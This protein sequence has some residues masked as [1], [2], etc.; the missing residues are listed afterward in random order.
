MNYNDVWVY[1]VKV[2]KSNCSIATI[3]FT[4]IAR[5]SNTVNHILPGRNIVQAA[6]AKPSFPSGTSRIKEGKG[7]ASHVLPKETKSPIYTDD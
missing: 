3:L 5:R 4:S 2:V 1:V 6:F 7:S